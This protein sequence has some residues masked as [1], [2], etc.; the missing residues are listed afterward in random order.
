MYKISESTDVREFCPGFTLDQIGGAVK[1]EVWG[2]TFADKEEY[3]EF[4]LFN[5]TGQ[6]IAANL[7]CVFNDR[8]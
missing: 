8:R 4:R 1:M 5:S 3:C 2:T 6:Q 7:W